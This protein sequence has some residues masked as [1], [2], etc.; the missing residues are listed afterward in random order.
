MNRFAQVFFALTVCLCSVTGQTRYLNEIF[1][2][3]NIREGVQYGSNINNVGQPV[4]LLMDY[5]QPASDT[6]AR[7]P[8]IVF[9]HGGAF[10][11]GSR[12]ESKVREF[13]TRFSRRGY[14]TSSIDYRLGVSNPFSRSDFIQAGYRAMQDAKAAVR[15]FRRQDVADSLRVDTTRI[16][17]GGFSAGAFSALNAACLDAS[18][19]TPE[20]DTTLLG[21][22]E[23]NSG[24]PGHSSRVLALMNC[25]GG[26]LDTLVVDPGDIPMIS[27]HGTS[28]PVVPYTSGI[29]IFA[30]IYLY[31]SSTITARLR[32]LG[33]RTY[34]I[35]MP[36]VGHGFPS[37]SVQN[38]FWTDTTIVSTA[39][40]FYPFV[41][42]T[43][44]ALAANQQP[45]N[46]ILEQ[47]Y[48]NPFNPVT[49]F[50]FSIVNRQLTILKV[51]DVLGREV[52]AL[53]N[54][55]KQPGTYKVRWDASGRASGVYFYRLQTGSLVD[56]KELILLR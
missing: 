21:N 5:F 35:P 29:S 48:P 22:I 1:S 28:D 37:D 26:L 10:V 7:R 27:V 11:T 40:F 45:G 14:I 25:W 4:T 6:M 38:S 17:L 32:S 49:N 51:Y 31:G 13:C 18:E 55:V 56:V 2:G 36:G 34:L 41:G 20:I 23:G 8:V 39:L 15:Y 19:L 3:V 54:E 24:N 33:I 9:V 53:V 52:A 42:P 44:V 12:T 43:A 30:G 50:Q 46:F 16:F 47:N